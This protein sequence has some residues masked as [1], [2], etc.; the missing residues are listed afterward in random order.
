MVAIELI[1]TDSEEAGQEVVDL[2]EWNAYIR[3]YL[4][5]IFNIYMPAQNV[6]AQGEQKSYFCVFWRKIKKFFFKNHL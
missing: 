5:V 4:K 1:D 3:S 6:L 2:A